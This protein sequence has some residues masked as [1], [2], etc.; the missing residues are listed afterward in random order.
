MQATYKLL[1][2][3]AATDDHSTSC[4]IDDNIETLKRGVE[5]IARLDDRLYTRPNRELSLSGVGVHFRHCIDFYHNFLVGVESGRVN[6]DLRERDERLE[7]NR[8]F[9]VARLGSLIADLSRL[10]VIKDDR[11][12]EV[13]L[14]GASDFDWSISSLKRE[15]QFLLSH[16]LHHYALIRAED[17]ERGS[18]WFSRRGGAVILA[19]RFVPGMRLP[20]YFAAGLLHTSFWR[21]TLYFSL[22]AAVWTPL[23]VGLSWAL[24]AEALK[25]AFLVNQSLFIKALAACAVV[26]LIIRL[27][28]KVSTYRRRRLH[29][30]SWR[31]LTRWEFWPPWMFYPPVICYVAYL[32]LKHRGLTVFTA[33]NP[34]I[35]GGG[36]M[37]ESKMEILR[38]LSPTDDFVARA[39][40][41]A[42]S[43]DLDARIRM[44]ENFMAG[45]GIGFPVV[46]KPDQGQRGSGV[47]VV[48]SQVE[49]NDYLRRTAVDTIIQEYAPGAEFGV[50][51]YRLPGEDRGR[52]F[53]IT[54]KRFPVVVGDGESDLERLILQDEQAVCMARFYLR[55]QRDRL[56]ETPAAGERVQLVELGT[57]CRGAIFLDGG[58][59]K[60]ESLEEAFDRISRSFEGFYFG[61]FDVRTPAVEEFK[62]GR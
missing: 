29:V 46:L 21:F 23:L 53:S 40:L 48:R 17:V 19:S 32:M 54:E 51:Y 33:A 61:R 56:W 5:L 12:F 39:A 42:A 15:L 25:S 45:R 1:T 59:V 43:L 8:L 28:T 41:I 14:E 58:W 50:F 9:A 31:R 27:A 34:A 6:Y 16:T 7:Q 47:V 52:I 24:G 35:I 2:R 62:Q 55:K 11:V 49:L 36:F 18:A 3:A 26:Y 4:L 10:P 38:G 44:A 37:G 13:T 57:H 60:T 20:T 30:S 22:A